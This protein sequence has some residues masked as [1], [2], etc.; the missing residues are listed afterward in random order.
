MFTHH[1]QTLQAIAFFLLLAVPALG[2]TIV[3][4]LQDLLGTYQYDTLGATPLGSYKSATVQTGYGLADV[5]KVRLVLEGSSSP[6]VVRGD[7]VLRENQ[8]VVTDSMF[9]ILSH[10]CYDGYGDLPGL[11]PGEFVFNTEFDAPYD[12]HRPVGGPPGTDN[13]SATI[14]IYLCAINPIQGPPAFF[15]PPAEGTSWNWYDGLVMVEPATATVT[16][17]YLVLEGPGVPEP[18]TLSLLALGGLLVLRRRR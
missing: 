5:T 11:A 4:P 15:V 14:E 12:T 7:G 17:A 13:F 16:N 6:A 2:G 18:A 8:E 1:R 9:S 3:V 10:I